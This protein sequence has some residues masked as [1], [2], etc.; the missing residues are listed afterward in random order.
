MLGR[1]HGIRENSDNRERT[2]NTPKARRTARIPRFESATD[3]GRPRFLRQG[4]DP[5]VE[6]PVQVVRVEI[7]HHAH[8]LD[9]SVG[10]D[11]QSL[12]LPELGH[13]SG[14]ALVV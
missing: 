4:A 5:L 8:P 11:R 2:L 14:Q 10:V 12:G 9:F 3:K 13:V 6:L 7:Q 1:R